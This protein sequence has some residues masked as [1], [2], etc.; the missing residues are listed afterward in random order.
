MSEIH[1][2]IANEVLFFIIIAVSLNLLMG[3]LGLLSVAQASFAGIGAYTVAKLTIGED[4]SFFPAILIGTAF[5]TIA[6]VL[7]TLPAIRLKLEHLILLTL[8]FAIVLVSVANGIPEL[9]G[10]YGLLGIPFPKIAGQTLIQPSEYFW[11]FLVSGGIV[12]LIYWRMGQSPYGRVLR[13][14][15]ED[16]TA[17]RSLGKN[18]FVYKMQ[19]AAV[20]SAFAG[21][22]GCLWAYYSQLVT[23][24]PY[25]VNASLL[26]VTMV[27]FGG[28]GSL[29]GPVV[30][31]IAIVISTD[32]LEAIFDVSPEKA[33]LIRLMAYGIA[34]ILIIRLRPQGLIPEG[35]SFVALGRRIVG[36]FKG[37]VGQAGPQPA[38]AHASAAPVGSLAEESSA[39]LGGAMARGSDG[40]TALATATPSA[41]SSNG[42]TVKVEGLNK[43][44]GGIIAADDVRIELPV[45]QITGL[46][47]PNGAGKTTLFSLLTGMLPQDSG[48]VQL[49]GQDITDMRMDVIARHGMVRS[50]QDV[51]L[52]QRL[53]VL[54]NVMVGFQDHP[55]E[56][57]FS[58]FF[59]PIAV[60]NAEKRNRARA[61]ELLSFVGLADRAGWPAGALAFGDQKLVA[62]AR[63]LATGADVMLLDEP[64]SGIDPQWVENVAGVVRA[65]PSLGKTV[66]IVEHNL[67]ALE[68]V[69]DRC[70][71]MEFGKIT[72]E[73]TLQSLMDEPRLREA[74]F[75]R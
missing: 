39:R 8:A 37:G 55:G 10:L 21:V 24:Q 29:L 1:Y 15:R 70:Y 58:L 68:R 57:L 52:F 16:E 74:Y 65:L 22:A 49:K 11:L 63:L 28:M 27:I 41:H 9:G 35:F 69:V 19:V 36:L 71:F 34:I 3:Y 7:L 46:V 42:T 50:F 14:I 30:G 72:G 32:V 44:F 20:T 60:W 75:G 53:S 4:F 17:A 64:T 6:G 5:A 54:D 62:I 56:G 33:S 48:R 67:H 66:C 61:M 25:A 2:D 73:G 43:R 12:F 13:A 23:P 59:R 18:I 26:A 51:R 40:A 45:N 31:A 47:G 38:L